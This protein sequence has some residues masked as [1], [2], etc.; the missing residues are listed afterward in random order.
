MTRKLGLVVFMTCTVLLAG[1]GPAPTGTPAAQPTEEYRPV[2]RLSGEVAPAVWATLSSHSGGT[3][4]EVLVQPGDDV[5]TDQLLARLDS[6]DAR[7]AVQQAQAALDTA[8]AERELMLAG[9]R[10]EEIAV[11]EAQLAAAE[12]AASQAVAARDQLAAGATEAEIA[13]ARANLAAAVAGEKEVR[14]AYD[15]LTAQGIHGWV[16]EQAI[17]RLR[18]AEEARAAAEAALARAEGGAGAQARA[19]EA[20]VWAAAAR[21]DVAKAQLEL[22]RAGATEEAVAAA[23]A[24]VAR[25]EAALDAARVALSRCDIRAP[26]AS[27]VGVVYVREGE[28]VAPGQPVVSVGDLSTLQVEITDLNDIDVARV[29]TGQRATLSF[30]ALPDQV[31]TGTVT[32]ISP[33]PEPVAGAIRYEAVVELDEIDPA[34]RWGMVT[35]FLDIEV[36]E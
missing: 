33:M 8:R 24:G 31:F 6:R 22:L 11:A 30:D 34:L 17:L 13:A 3:A 28:L 26:F 2:V 29:E 18:A 36:A 14:D 10:A 1:C 20:A 23:E 32:R 25:A 5:S 35:A 7:L 9:P 16:E 19:A 4:V 12:A 15:Q 21:R 27:T